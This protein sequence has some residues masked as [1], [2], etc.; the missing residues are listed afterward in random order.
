MFN[1]GKGGVRIMALGELIGIQYRK[2]RCQNHGS[3]GA[4][5]C[6]TQDWEV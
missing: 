2:G 1:I 5:W 3:M 4:D 6:S